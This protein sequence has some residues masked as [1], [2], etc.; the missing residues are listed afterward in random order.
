VATGGTGS[1]LAVASGSS[2]AGVAAVA[3]RQKVAGITAD[4]YG[5]LPSWC[6]SLLSVELL[7]AVLQELSALPA[8][9]CVGEEIVPC[10]TLLRVLLHT[11]W[12]GCFT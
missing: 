12:R 6:R 11:V 8:G 2:C 1:C 5:T 3:L 9:R 10:C 7:N 4:E